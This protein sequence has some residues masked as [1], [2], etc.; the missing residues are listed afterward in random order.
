MPSAGASAAGMGGSTPNPNSGGAS[1]A[2]LSGAPGSS[3]T[4]SGG[5]NNGGASSGG[6]AGDPSGASAGSAG[7]AA[8]IGGQDMYPLMKVLPLFTAADVPAKGPMESPSSKQGWTPP[9]TLPT[10]TGNGIA[11]HP[12]LYVGENYNRIILVNGGKVIWTY[13]TLPGYELDD[14]WMM[15]NGNILYSHMTFIEE[16]T[17]KKEVVWHY[18]PASGEIHTLQP[19]GLDKVLFVENALPMARVRIYNKKTATFE[20]DHPLAAAGTQHGQFRRFRMTGAGTYLGSFL[21][22]A[23]VV[24]FDSHFKEL[25]SFATPSPWSGVRL[26]NGNTLIQDEKESTAKEVDPAGQVV[27]QLARSGLTLPAGTMMGNTQTSERLS[28]GNTVMF[29]NGGT[30]VNNIQAVEVTPD[31][32]IV[33][34]LQDWM[35]LGDATSAQFLDEPGYPEIPG[36]TNH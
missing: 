3:G 1:G 32:Q 11:Q 33:W 17:P 25:W 6:D 34:V 8:G 4:D 24:E 22:G 36:D 31:K 19:I 30:N 29:G 18:K 15:S 27:W 13:D 9:T 20:V 10:R 2:G 12:M 23:K 7:S 35:H 5:T 21:S 14:V 28:N 26:K 16:I